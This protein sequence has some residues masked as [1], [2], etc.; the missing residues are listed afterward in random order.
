MPRAQGAFRRVKSY[1]THGVAWAADGTCS[2]PLMLMNTYVI[3]AAV[4]LG[5]CR[6]S[7]H[8]VEKVQ[9]LCMR[10]I[11]SSRL[12]VH[13]WAMCMVQVQQDVGQWVDV[14]PTANQVI[15]LAGYTLEVALGVARAAKHRVV[16]EAAML[17]VDTHIC[18]CD[19]IVVWW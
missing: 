15:I 9:T 18:K 13:S 19:A 5:Q 3:G 4:C 7:V 2:Q 6:L 17:R 16:S 10:G 8:C 1:I 12:D 11:P 14:Q